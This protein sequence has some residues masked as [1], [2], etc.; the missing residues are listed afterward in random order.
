VHRAST[1]LSRGSFSLTPSLRRAP[2]QRCDGA[3]RGAGIAGAAGG[4][5][6]GAAWMGKTWCV[7][8]IVRV[9]TTSL[10][11]AITD[12]LLNIRFN[13]GFDGGTLFSMFG[14]SPR[15]GAP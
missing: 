6:K 11:Y 8:R 5:I 13:L 12:V 3:R 14:T 10:L 2:V 15:R 1:A 9:P 4:S 7:P